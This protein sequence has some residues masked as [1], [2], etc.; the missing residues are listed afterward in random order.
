MKHD[1]PQ[2]LHWRVFGFICTAL[3]GYALALGLAKGTEE[4]LRV[5]LD[6]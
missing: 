1:T 2:D 3:V 4:R 5:G 6:L